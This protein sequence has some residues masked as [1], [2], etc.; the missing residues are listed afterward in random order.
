M[1]DYTQRSN[2]SHSTEAVVQ[3]CSDVFHQLLGGLV[4]YPV[5]VQFQC[6][7]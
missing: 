4:A 5:L 2:M 6:H 7:L 3:S 1:S